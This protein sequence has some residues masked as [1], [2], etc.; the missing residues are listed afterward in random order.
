MFGDAETIFGNRRFQR[1]QYIGA[2]LN[3]FGQPQRADHIAATTDAFQSRRHF[4]QSRHAHPV[5]ARAQIGVGGGLKC[6]LAIAV[7]VRRVLRLDQHGKAGIFGPLVGS[8][9]AGYDRTSP[10]H[11]VEV[12]ALRDLIARGLQHLV[13]TP[14]AA[15]MA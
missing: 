13:D 1:A 11:R 12:I 6:L 2:G 15:W 10:A 7:L 3:A 14:L 9:G 5:I 8:V 4:H